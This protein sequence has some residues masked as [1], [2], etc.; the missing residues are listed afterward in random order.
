[1]GV[2][3]TGEGRYAGRELKAWG[4]RQT[5]LVQMGRAALDGDFVEF[6]A[7]VL[8]LPM[9]F[10]E[11]FVE[12]TTLR[13]DVVML[14]W[15]GPLVVNGGARSTH[16]SKHFENPYTSTD[17]PCTAMEIRYGADYLRLDCSV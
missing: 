4:E 9:S 12:A 5:W 16:R 17:L 13:G 14:T 10:G 15:D 8:A 6:Q 3:L 7:Q 1:M 2:R 11:D